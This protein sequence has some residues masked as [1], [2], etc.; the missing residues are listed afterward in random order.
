M[1][2]SNQLMRLIPFFFVFLNDVLHF[3]LQPFRSN[4]YLAPFFAVSHWQY[5]FGE[6]TNSTRAVG[7]LHVR[8]C[9]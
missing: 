3:T 1:I 7:D 9:F 5:L 8:H 2:R 4:C 6:N